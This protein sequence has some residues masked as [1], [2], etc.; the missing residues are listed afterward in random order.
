LTRPEQD[1]GKSRLQILLDIRAQTGV[2]AKEL[3][4]APQMSTAVQ[5]VWG[6]FCDLSRGRTAGM[7][8]NAIGWADMRAFFDLIGVKPL[9]WEISALRRIDDAFIESRLGTPTAKITTAQD[10]MRQIAK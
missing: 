6:W 7:T 8:I 10:M 1:T 9:R 5:H 2:I 4:E 3:R